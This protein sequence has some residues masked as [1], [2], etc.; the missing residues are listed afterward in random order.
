MA[1]IAKTFTEQPLPYE[2]LRSLVRDGDLLLWKPVGLPG[3]II[4]WGTRSCYSHASMAAWRHGRLWNLEMVQWRG[5]QHVH[6]SQQI[7]RYPGSC[8]VWRPRNLAFD[9]VGA[10][11]EMLWL[12]GQ[13]YGWWD[14]ARIAVRNVLPHCVLPQAVDSDDPEV[15][16]VCSA[17]YHWAARIG[18]GI[19]PCPGKADLDVSPRDLYAGGFADYLGT[20][21]LA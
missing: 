4:A 6:L 2:S 15:P 16:R 17:S 14:L 11:H 19:A 18:G 8:A 13:N 3:R 12:M 9:G 1:W 21:V 5:G 10:V 20:P 7:A